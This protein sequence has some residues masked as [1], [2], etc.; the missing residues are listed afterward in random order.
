MKRCLKIFVVLLLLSVTLAKAESVPTPLRSMFP[1]A[2]IPGLEIIRQES[3]TT[4]QRNF[5]LKD[6]EFDKNGYLKVAVPVEYLDHLASVNVADLGI[7]R[8]EGGPSILGFALLG[9]KNEGE[10][11]KSYFFGGRS[12][13]KILLTIW[14]FKEDGASLMVISDFQNQEI[15]GIRGTLSLA[16]NVNTKNCL[17]KMTFVGGTI[18]YEITISDVLTTGNL[19]KTPVPLVLEVARKLISFA[20]SENRHEER[21]H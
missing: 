20:Q 8:R 18:S 11:R 7:N 6:T 4:E 16:T 21:L 10:N 12:E 1:H 13:V 14:N 2:K 5:L 9:V 19:P 3:L 15:E 17:W